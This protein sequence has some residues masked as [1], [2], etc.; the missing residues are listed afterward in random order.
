MLLLKL[1]SFM[2]DV[3]EKGQILTAAS[4]TPGVFRAGP[5]HK[6]SGKP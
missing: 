3:L 6:L 5:R 4:K 2:T 1:M